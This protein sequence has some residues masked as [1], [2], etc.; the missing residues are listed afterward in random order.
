MTKKFKTTPILPREG[1][2]E[3]LCEKLPIFEPHDISAL[4]QEAKS[5]EKADVDRALVAATRRRTNE[6][7]LELLRCLGIDPSD[8]RVWEKGFY[9]LAF[10]H[11]GAGQISIYQRRT[12]RNA[13]KWTTSHDYLLLKEVT[14][15]K[16]NGLS[17]RDADKELA[18]DKTKKSQFPYRSWR[19]ASVRGGQ[20]NRE[21][22]LW[23]RLQKLKSN[24]RGLARI[25]GA[26]DGGLSSIE[27]LLFAST[28]SRL[29]QGGQKV[30]P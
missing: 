29:Q 7:L 6:Q 16:R 23:A 14:I 8:Q 21:D 13:A 11:H 4:I 3:T 26:V 28:F 1:E 5:T 27:A 20:K 12:N 10:C 19:H 30:R 18:A 9:L 24:S 25:L 22:A 15:L 2:R 17:E